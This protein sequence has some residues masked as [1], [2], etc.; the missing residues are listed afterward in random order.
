MAG[1]HTTSIS[2]V[3]SSVVGSWRTVND[4]YPCSGWPGRV[5]YVNP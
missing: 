4:S 2:N 1:R 5:A 3:T